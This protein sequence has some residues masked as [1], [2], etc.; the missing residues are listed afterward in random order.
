MISDI[1][2]AQEARTSLRYTQQTVKFEDKLQNSWKDKNKIL[3]GCVSSSIRIYSIKI[4]PVFELL[5]I[6]HLMF[7]TMPNPPCCTPPFV[8]KTGGRYIMGGTAGGFGKQAKFLLG[9]FA[10]I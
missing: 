3:I 7:T 9:G 2:F 10:A 6:R 8:R 4:R 1:I 5:V